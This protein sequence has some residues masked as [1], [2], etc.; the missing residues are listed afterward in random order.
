MRVWDL[1]Y[2]FAGIAA[3]SPIEQYRRCYHT[4]KK[5]RQ[6]NNHEN[7]GMAQRRFCHDLALRGH[8]AN[9]PGKFLIRVTLFVTNAHPLSLIFA[10]KI[11]EIPF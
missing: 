1:I 4:N 3:A 8:W 2:R 6:Q 5:W 11:E 10:N 7:G 9:Q